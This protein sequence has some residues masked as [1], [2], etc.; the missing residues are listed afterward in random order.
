MSSGKLSTETVWTIT[1]P[2]LCV[3]NAKSG[4]IAGGGSRNPD[5]PVQGIEVTRT[6]LILPVDHIHDRIRHGH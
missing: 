4:K 6:N 2:G 1:I 5:L 3:V